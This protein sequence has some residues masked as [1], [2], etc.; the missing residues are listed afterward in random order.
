MVEIEVP[1][2]RGEEIV[3][4]CSSCRLVWFDQ[5]EYE[6]LP[7][8]TETAV[9]QVQGDV[10][11]VDEPKSES[12]DWLGSLLHLPIAEKRPALRRAP[13]ATILVAVAI[14]VVSIAAWI[15]GGGALVGELGFVPAR[16]KE[17]FG[18]TMLSSFFLHADVLHLYGNLFFFLIVGPSAED[19]LGRGK[20][21]AFLLLSTIAGGVAH[22][23]V[24]P[25]STVPCVGASG[26]ISGVLA[27]YALKFPR[28]RFY[29]FQFGLFPRIMPAIVVFAFWIAWQGFF[30]YL[31]LRGEIDVSAAAH[32][33]GVAV[34]VVFW[35]VYRRS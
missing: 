34:G 17:T 22:I 8:A 6:A 24:D 27:F 33:G 9:L 20:F 29:A 7:K 30:L 28:A 2:R 23:L 16:W 25:S 31:Q 1:S 26:G 3:D 19:Y 11:L 35:V 4:V 5:T 18:L 13:L 21:L 10:L 12:E 15:F 14:V 32:L